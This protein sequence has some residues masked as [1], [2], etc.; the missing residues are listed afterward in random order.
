MELEAVTCE[1]GL[2]PEGPLWDYRTQ[3]LYW[4]D[5][6]RAELW[7]LAADRPPRRIYQSKDYI[8]GVWLAYGGNL[9]IAADQALYIISG[10]GEIQAR[11]TQTPD[12]GIGLRF[13]DGA[14]D[15]SG[16]LVI[17]TMGRAAEDYD[18]PIGALYRIDIDGRFETIITGLTI[19]N[20][21]DW[22]PDGRTMYV[23]DTMRRRILMAPADLEGPIVADD[24]PAFI[25]P[26]EAAY[27]DGLCVR[28]DGVIIVAEILGG[29]LSFFSRTGE[30]LERCRL[31]VSCPTAP[32]FGGRK[33]DILFLTTST[34]LLP[35]N[36]GEERAGHVLQL[37]GAGN[38]KPSHVF[39]E[40]RERTE[41]E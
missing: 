35:Q 24:C 9:L 38:G 40:P 30:I 15:A 6:E 36:H 8:S 7:G 22:S 33:F 4:V 3:S 34:H 21:V 10:S 39:G 29:A 25:L 31:P 14:V 17:G 12:P 2:L 1:P 23:A 18:K 28:A 16:R 41:D 13:N 20:G 27:P 11:L 32:C 5:I 26:S 37:A 19:S